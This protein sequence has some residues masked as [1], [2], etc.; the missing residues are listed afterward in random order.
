M[1]AGIGVMIFMIPINGLIA[2]M[3]KNMQ[4]KQM[5][6]KDTR[7]RLMTEILNNMKSIKLYSWGAP[8]MEKLQHVRNDLE[9]KTL[10]EIGIAQST[11]SF[12]WST[13]PFLVSCEYSHHLIIVLHA[14]EE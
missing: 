2:R 9:L 6:N 14:D 13:T 8:F 11:T 12:T 4:K 5:K 3:M 10:K 1:F 7:T